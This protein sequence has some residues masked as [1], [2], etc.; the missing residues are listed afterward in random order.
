MPT[1]KSKTSASI[2][3]KSKAT[4]KPKPGAK[5]FNTTIYLII[6]VVIIVAAFSIWL[7]NNPNKI[8]SQANQ[9]SS[10]NATLSLVSSASSVAVGDKIHL[11][12]FSDSKDVKNNAVQAV[13]KF[14]SKNLQLVKISSDNSAYPIKATET[15]T[16][17][18]ITIS[19]GV[20]VGIINKQLV[21]DMEFVAKES[22]DA[23]FSY[24]KSQTFLV[25]S[26]TNKNLLNNDSFETT[27][28][29]VIK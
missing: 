11:Q 16:A 15:S 25:S 2:S 23:E 18:S 14:P 24:D 13:I 3:Q 26:D 6:L 7:L 17:D 4:K 19:R 5:Q 20:I 28:I 1:K 12:L 22:G 9:A 21:T 10:T 27:N 8:G 29:E